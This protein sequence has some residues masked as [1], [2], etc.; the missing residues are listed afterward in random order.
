MLAAVVT[1]VPLL[2]DT[3]RNTIENVI[4]PS[5][6]GDVDRLRVAVKLLPPVLVAVTVTPAIVTVSDDVSS[7]SDAVKLSVTLSPAFAYAVFEPLD[8]NCTFDRVGAVESATNMFTY[9]Q[10]RA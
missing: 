7:A 4:T 2:P 6:G 5:L 1:V 3:S 8:T 9:Q 10:S